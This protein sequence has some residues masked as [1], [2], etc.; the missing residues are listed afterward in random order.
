MAS[1]S[2]IEAAT[3]RPAAEWS[4]GHPFGPKAIAALLVATVLLALSAPRVDVGSMVTL[5]GEWLAAQLGFRESSQ[6]GKGLGRVAETM[7]PLQISERTEL[8]HITDFD[9]SQLPWLARVERTEIRE[10][11]LNPTTLA[12]EAVIETKEYL[13]EPYGYLLRVL[14]KML[15]T[16]EIG[17][18]G[19]IVA[20]V[21]SIPLAFWS[22]R[23][24]AP[25]PLVYTSAR[26]AVS[27]LRAIPEMISALFLVLAYGFG[28][29][30][31]ILALG[32]HA[33]GFLGKFYAEDIENADKGPQEALFAVGANK[34]KV[35]WFAVLPQVLPQYVAYTLYILDRNV[36]MA[37]VIGIVGAGGI[38]QELKGRCEMFNYGH[39]TTALIVLFITVFLLDRVSAILR[40]NLS[41]RSYQSSIT[42]CLP[43]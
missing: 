15:E 21:V 3:A 37:T 24:Y 29:T 43:A 23:N 18:W 12:T 27:F 5:T 33:A 1:P 30:A 9:R 35:L 25:H 20:I 13:I 26:A 11:K 31:G 32:F 2:L 17:L 4:I 28:P 36:R 16:L 22:A 10:L 41:K 34:L 38:G 7:F 39:V 6:V 19:T 42:Q 40:K 8:S 14:A